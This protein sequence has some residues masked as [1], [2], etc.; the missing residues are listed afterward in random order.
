MSTTTLDQQSASTLVPSRTTTPRTGTSLVVATTAE[1][2]P[3]SPH[4]VGR[5]GVAGLLIG[6][7]AV[8]ATVGLLSGTAAATVTGV[9]LVVA[10]AFVLASREMGDSHVAD[11]PED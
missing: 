2:P 1:R 11:D 4:R 3:S 6:A 9:T 8:L 5:V 7:S 10:T